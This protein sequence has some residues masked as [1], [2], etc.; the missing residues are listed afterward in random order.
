MSTEET[1][2]TQMVRRVA[3]GEHRLANELFLLVYER[4]QE[5]AGSLL[6][7]ERA[8]HTLQPTALVHEAWL[9]LVDAKDLDWRDRAHYASIAARAM[10]QVLVDH[11]R[12]RSAGKRGAHW[13]RITLS[14][15]EASGQRG[16]DVTAIDQALSRLHGVNE[17]AARVLEM[18]V[19]GDLT[20]AEIAAVLDVSERTA[21]KDLTIGRA[22]LLRELD[23]TAG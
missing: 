9:R 4:L 5:L 15:L 10:R 11:A 3:A 8:D 14:A 17:R 22:W 20:V 7:R 21:S 23:A 18:T 2:A 6:R 13:E 12:R 16:V 1:N 19:F